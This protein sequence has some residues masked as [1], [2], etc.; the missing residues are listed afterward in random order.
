[1]ANSPRG[2]STTII[3]EWPRLKR[4]TPYVVT[5]QL[6]QYQLTK[7][8]YGEFPSSRLWAILQ[9]G[10]PAPAHGSSDTPGWGNSFRSLDP[11]DPVKVNQRIQNLVDHLRTRR[12]NQRRASDTRQA[13]RSLHAWVMPRRAPRNTTGTNVFHYHL[14][15]A[16]H[17]KPPLGRFVERKPLCV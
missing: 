13:R 12:T 2:N 11:H 4:S 14:R 3:P 8:S 9:F 7:N 15:K 5:N 17:F 10:A 1:M 16:V 6:T